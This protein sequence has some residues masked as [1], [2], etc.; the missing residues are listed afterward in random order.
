MTVVG[1]IDSTRARLRAFAKDGRDRC[2]SLYPG[3]SFDDAVW[4]VRGFHRTPADKVANIYFTAFDT[5]AA[6]PAPFAM[7]AKA[8]VISG[9]PHS[10]SRLKQRADATRFLWRAVKERL[11]PNAA[12]RFTW[13][14]FETR[15]VLRSEELLIEERRKS[16][17][18]IAITLLDFVSVLAQHGL[19]QPLPIRPMSKRETDG[20]TRRPGEEFEAGAVLPT[21]SLVRALATVFATATEWRDQFFAAIFGLML[22]SGIRA[23]EVASL[24]KNPLERVRRT[25]RDTTG[26][27][28]SRTFVRVRRY[29]SKSNRAGGRGQP[30][31]EFEWLTDAQAELFEMCVKMLRRLTA[32]SRR[33]IAQGERNGCSWR[34]PQGIRRDSWVDANDLVRWFGCS[35]SS[36]NLWLRGPLR[37][38]EVSVDPAG[39]RTPR[40]CRG[41]DVERF[42]ASRTHIRAWMPL[43]DRGDGRP[44]LASEALIVM[45]VG[46]GDRQG[47]F[48]L[49]VPQRITLAQFARWL[50]TG[51]SSR[52]SGVFERF[53]AQKGTAFIEPDGTTVRCRTH[54]FRHL[55]VTNALR[56]GATTLDIARWQGREHLG[57]I[58]RYDQRSMA[59]RVRVAKDSIR[60]GRMR[61]PVASIYA[62]LADGENDA[63]LDSVVS[64]FHVTPLGFCVH[65]FSM[66]PCPYALNCLRG[67]PSY[68]V[69]AEDPDQRRELVQLQRRCRTARAKVDERESVPQ[70]WRDQLSETERAVEKVLESLEGGGVVRPFEGARPLFR[71]MLRE[72]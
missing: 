54:Q 27:L 7:A 41:R 37:G 15:D 8:W 9:G 57:D 3:L 62:S 10:L 67:C 39:V 59:E 12:A 68:L 1:V 14:L 33:I 32:R 55:F 61:G 66:V 38:G 43:A 49:P 58:A 35:R 31:L 24:P 25:V 2:A 30:A 17:Y 5:A 48:T 26:A 64:A 45:R 47:E 16:V 34:L 63:W 44:L 51:E 6:L 60:S 22:A 56:A 4:D 21:E 19:C 40:R 71:P 36:A 65:D 50:G 53:R 70:A 29:K 42:I 13:A 11:G 18:K 28:V 23:N 72:E 46:E 20:N 69:D 52:E